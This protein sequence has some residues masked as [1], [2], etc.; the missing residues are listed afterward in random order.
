[1]ADVENIIRFRQEG[2]QTV[3]ATYDNLIKKAVEAEAA[4]ESVFTGV[5]DEAKKAA[6][7][8]SEV[9]AALT[10]QGA[11]AK[12]TEAINKRAA[13]SFTSIRD[14]AKAMA[15]GVKDAI[16]DVTVF[17]VSINSA[18]EKLGSARKALGDYANS[19]KVAGAAAKASGSAS[20][21]GF[22]LARVG[23]LALRTALGP[24]GL[25]ITAVGIAFTLLAKAAQ[26]SEPIMDAVA[27][28]TAAVSAGFD[29]LIDR[30]I[31]VTETIF[32]FTKA[33]GQ[34][35]FGDAS[36][37]IESFGKASDSAKVATANLNE[38][39]SREIALAAK[40][41]EQL[42]DLERSE[43]LLNVQ[44]R[45]TAARLKEL[46]FVAEDTARTTRERLA[47]SEEAFALEDSLAQRELANAKQKVAN[48]LASLEV[49]G[50]TLTL[51]KELEAGTISYNNVVT[52]LG[53]ATSGQKD[54]EETL[55]LI[56]KVGDLRAANFERQTTQRNKTET[57]RRDGEQRRLKAIE[58]Q[59]KAEEELGKFRQQLADQLTQLAIDESVGIERI[60]L[61]RKVAQSQIN[62]AEEV[63]KAKFKA[64]GEVFDVESEFTKLRE[65]ADKDAASRTSA[66]RFEQSKKDIDAA[67]L[68]Q[69]TELELS[70]TT[71]NALL[72]REEVLAFERN[73]IVRKSLQ[74]QRAI[75]LEEFGKDSTEVLTID[76]QLR[77]TEDGDQQ[78]TDGFIERTRADAL[79]AIDVRQQ[80]RLAE[81]EL[82]QKSED[83]NLNVVQF[84]EREKT[85]VLI[86]GLLERRKIILAQ[87]KDSKAPEVKL[88][89]L[90]IQRLQ[91]QVDG[92]DNINLGPL[93]KIKK[94]VAEALKLDEAVFEEA[95]KL[96]GSAVQD[97]A[98]SIV[99][100][101]E[102]VYERQLIEQDKLISQIDDRVD[103]LRSALDTE[104]ELQEQGFANN[105]GLAQADLDAELARK[106]AANAKRLEIERR[107]AKQQLL[108][109]AAQQASSLALAVANLLANEALKGLPGIILA[110]TLGLATIFAA[111]QKAKT[112]AASFTVPEFRDGGF[113]QGVLVGPS[114]EA[115][116]I[117]GVYSS[118]EGQR[119][120]SM[121]GSE[122]VMPLKETQQYAPALEAMRTGS[123]KGMK[124]ADV[125]T[126]L[127]RNP[128]LGINP[129]TSFTPK[130]DNTKDV[131]NKAAERIER[132]IAGQLQIVPDGKGGYVFV[133]PQGTISPYG[134]KI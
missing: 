117:L 92:L 17:G 53:Q 101:L 105:A 94:R 104:L 126:M 48:N 5:A 7:G 37:A 54:V 74:D 106:E 90:E 102:S 95:F 78:A 70:T 99:A 128:T 42:I 73:K 124:D 85:R 44:R 31:A 2:E 112:T 62:A 33:L 75:A 35:A 122:Y 103:T 18:R 51:L 109:D 115:G 58:A 3:L 21:V 66:F 41:K 55:E 113:A 129:R 134:N 56:G 111:V 97:S 27:V 88:V 125:L 40:L 26:R 38:E 11:K 60:E 59:R 30:A 57:I 121:E 12:E 87:F 13:I 130:P 10:T 81:N 64:A 14:A 93:D 91:D 9:V 25:I 123:I 119:V 83:E 4:T 61:E 63:A 84:K 16:G 76:V 68:R 47:A 39:L 114:H 72:T 45:L 107:A 127:G 52:Q 65:A 50:K 8:T 49:D 133:S 23:A 98:S 67:T 29:V 20:A 79:K 82:I 28:V 116:G 36:G 19:S 24:I 96:A 100:G 6:A 118:P 131:V 22:G 34:L 69:L 80:L 15:G 108:I 32:F 1:M 46:N 110:G 43:L 120:L 86:D 77:S 132:A 71:G 89:D